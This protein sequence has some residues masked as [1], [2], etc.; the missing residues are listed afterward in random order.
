MLVDEGRDLVCFLSV[1]AEN[2]RVPPFQSGS[3]SFEIN[4]PAPIKIHSNIY[5]AIEDTKHSVVIDEMDHLL[6][7][8][9]RPEY[10]DPQLKPFDLDYENA[11]AGHAHFRELLS[12]L[13]NYSP[14]PF[15][16]FYWTA[17]STQ[18]YYDHHEGPSGFEADRDRAQR[19]SELA[20]YFSGFLGE[21]DQCHFGTLAAQAVL[22][23]VSNLLCSSTVNNNF[24]SFRCLQGKVEVP[25][26]DVV[27]GTT[28]PT[29]AASCLAYLVAAFASEPSVNFLDFTHRFCFMLHAIYVEHLFK[30]IVSSEWSC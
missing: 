28:D 25:L 24:F 16:T 17:P 23:P 27:A 26:R 21:E 20:G 30:N 5:G 9:F 7:V 29:Q 3:F 2:K 15:H 8:F 6:T 12:V 10:F 14:N 22:H 11:T 13:P 18:T 19:W 1:T 4:N